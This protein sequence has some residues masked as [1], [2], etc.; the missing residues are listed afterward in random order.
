MAVSRRE[1]DTDPNYSV[2]LG[3]LE[4]VDKENS[5]P[6]IEDVISDLRDDVNDLCDLANK[7]DG[8]TFDYTPA[9]GSAKAK[10]VITVADGTQFTLKA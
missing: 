2:A 7:V 9:K 4:G 5:E 1:K 8:L 10:L 3:F 6:M